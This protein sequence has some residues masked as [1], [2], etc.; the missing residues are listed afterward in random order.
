MSDCVS[1]SCMNCNKKSFYKPKKSKQ[2]KRKKKFC[3]PKKNV[4]CHFCISCVE[5]GLTLI[6]QWDPD[7][8]NEDTEFIM[9][10]KA[11]K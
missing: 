2:A 5:P 11:N 3:A 7:S 9:G 10:V 8:I 4:Y 6:F 1:G